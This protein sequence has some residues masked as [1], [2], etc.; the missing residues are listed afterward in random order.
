MKPAVPGVARRAARPATR[1]S[2]SSASSAAS[3]GECTWPTEQ[4]AD[5][6]PFGKKFVGQGEPGNGMGEDLELPKA[7]EP[8]GADRELHRAARSSASAATCTRAA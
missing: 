8:F 2:T 5:F 4:C 7:G 3:D 6:D 1:C